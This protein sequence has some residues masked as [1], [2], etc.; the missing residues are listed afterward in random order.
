MLFFK[1]KTVP[2]PSVYS[3]WNRELTRLEGAFLS[4]ADAALLRGGDLRDRKY[5]LESLQADLTAFSEK[6]LSFYI[7]AVS[8]SVER[9]LGENDPEYLTLV[10]R[11]HHA[12]RARLYFF[13]ALEFLEKDYRRTLAER[14]SEK[15]DAF[16]RELIGYFDRAARYSAPMEDVARSVKRYVGV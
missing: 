8:A 16:D 6:Q 1:R 7:R 4:E 3:E 5:S 2:Y 15:L 12:A 10:L 11:R 14:L 13:E 9:Y